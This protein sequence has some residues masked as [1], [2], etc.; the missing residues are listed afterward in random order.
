MQRHQSFLQAGSLRSIPVTGESQSPRG[1]RAPAHLHQQ[2]KSIEIDPQRPD[3][4][5]KAAPG[6]PGGYDTAKVCTRH[7]WAS[8]FDN[9]DPIPACPLCIAEH[10]AERGK[11]RYSVIHTTLAF[12]L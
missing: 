5:R 11:L 2:R 7:Q 9:W 1:E 12:E 3:V 10:E 8:D 4:V 6:Y